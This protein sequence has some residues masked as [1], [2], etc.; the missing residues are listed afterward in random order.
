MRKSLFL[1][2]FL[3]LFLLFPLTG[4]NEEYDSSTDERITADLPGTWRL[5]ESQTDSA[6]Q[7]VLSRE[8]LFT[9]TTAKNFHVEY[10][11]TSLSKTVS[12]SISGTWNVKRE[13]LE[14]KYDLPSFTSEGLTSQQVDIII[15]S[16]KDNNLLLEDLKG[17]NQ[18]YGMP[19]ELSR[20]GSTSGMMKLSK[21]YDFGGIYTI[22]TGMTP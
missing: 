5:F 17:S 6:E 21:S 16:F 13:T 4:C 15:S 18:P 20:Q 11:R 2:P 3:A 14:L 10:I 8:V 1:I 9:F 22:Y 19:I 7:V 12:Y